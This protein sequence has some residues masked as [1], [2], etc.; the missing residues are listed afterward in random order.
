MAHERAAVGVHPLRAVAGVGGYDKYVRVDLSKDNSPYKTGARTMSSVRSSVV[1]TVRS[2]RE[3]KPQFR[4]LVGIPPLPRGSDESPARRGRSSYSVGSRWAGADRLGDP[5][6]E[7]PRPGGQ[8]EEGERLA[9]DAVAIAGET[10]F[11]LHQTMSARRT[12]RRVDPP[13]DVERGRSRSREC[14]Q[15]V[16][17][18]ANAR[19]GG[20]R[21]L[22]RISSP[23]SIVEP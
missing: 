16:R 21:S 5:S 9:R 20:V 7:D 2:R 6:L 10:D 23:R 14:A 3:P 15:G 17:P 13:G 18:E 12:Y 4:G 11:L 8:E 1:R 22:Q 19:P